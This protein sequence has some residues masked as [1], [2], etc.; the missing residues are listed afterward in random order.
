[1]SRARV[2]ADREAVAGRGTSLADG[3]LV[4]GVVRSEGCLERDVAVREQRLDHIAFDEAVHVDVEAQLNGVVV[5]PVP[6]ADV[7]EEGTDAHVGDRVVALKE[8]LAAPHVVL[9]DVV[10]GRGLPGAGAGPAVAAGLELD[11]EG[12]GAGRV[13]ALEVLVDWVDFLVD[14]ARAG[15]DHRSAGDEQGQSQR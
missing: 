2:D 12:H 11:L 1:M 10:D 5:A 13:P 3:A 4:Q 9:G 8:H 7:R 14:A 6:D 15:E